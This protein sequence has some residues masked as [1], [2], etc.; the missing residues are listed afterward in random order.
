[1]IWGLRRPRR[2]LAVVGLA[3]G[4]FASTVSIV[5]NPA[6]ARA[7]TGIFRLALIQV[8]TTDATVHRYTQAQLRDAADEIK[9]YFDW[10]SNGTL[11]V[12]VRVGKAELSHDRD[13]YFGPCDPDSAGTETRHP[14]PPFLQQDAM[15]EAVDNGLSLDGVHGVGL[16]FPWADGDVTYGA[17][18]P[19]VSGTSPDRDFLQSFLFED[20]DPYPSCPQRFSTPTDTPGPSHVYWNAWAHEFGHQLQQIDGIVLYGNWNG[21]AAGYGDG[22]DL[23]DSGYP[24]S[25]SVYGLSAPDIGDKR[26]FPGWLPPSKIRTIPRPSSGMTTNDVTLSPITVASS[27]TTHFQGIKIPIAPGV[28]ETVEARRRTRADSLDVHPGIWDQGIHIQQVFE[29]ADPPVVTVDSCD[30]LVV[31]GGCIRDSSDPRTAMCPASARTAADS[32]PFCYPF[33]LWHPGNTY[34][35]TVNNVT[36]D[37]RSY[38]STSNTYVVRVMRGV[39]AG[40]P[41]VSIT[42]WLTAPLNT[43][44]T[45]DVWIDS[46]C[47]GFGVY[48]FGVGADGEP[49]GNG[50]QPCA[51]HPNRLYA[52]ITN[53]GTADATDVVVSFD[54]ANPLGVGIARATGW[55]GIRTVTFNDFSG[56]ASIARGDHV[57][58]WVPWNPVVPASAI[59]DPTGFAF[60]SCVRV[61]ARPVAGEVVYANQDG[62]GEQENFFYFQAQTSGGRA[63]GRDEGPI[64]LRGKIFLRNID[65]KKGTTKPRTFF[66]ATHDN[67]PDGWEFSVYGGRRAITLAPG[68]VAQIPIKVVVPADAPTGRIFRLDVSAGTPVDLVNRA[69]P[70]NYF[71]SRVHHTYTVV[72]GDVIAV[73]TVKPSKI[74][75]QATQDGDGNISVTGTVIPGIKG[76]YITID[77]IDSKGVVTSHLIQTDPSGAFTDDLKGGDD[78]EWTVRALWVG[79]M[80]FSS[81]RT[82]IQPDQV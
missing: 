66:F 82:E 41:D 70:R 24:D 58:V 23:M 31:S 17:F 74:D 67:F 73:H 69:I 2:R 16:L 32:R 22:Y 6:P 47:N 59:T 7:R 65:T 28:Y 52:R 75:L 61:H 20:C 9:Q 27:T 64:I 21:H 79:N 5:H 36:I 14:C 33:P 25:E 56:L 62:A 3:V 8:S 76:T 55:A 1:M 48:Q 12:Q 45:K 57:D 40:I 42:P 35:D 29:N 30:T 60:H 77:Y 38:D 81:A 49:N 72:A 78:H 13:Y 53:I 50:D 34:A 54:R 18:T 10:L 11:D 15:Q 44:E 68:Q 46:S 43:W 39:P 19:H 51:N 26:I 80:A 37:V 71:V 4:L 63:G